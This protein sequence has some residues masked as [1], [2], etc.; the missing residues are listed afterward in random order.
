MKDFPKRF[1]YKV[2]FANVEYSYRTNSTKQNVLKLI[3][4]SLWVVA[5]VL[6]LTATIRVYQ[7]MGADSILWVYLLG[8]ASFVTS[9]ITIAKLF[10]MMLVALR[11]FQKKPMFT[12]EQDAFEKEQPVQNTNV[13][14]DALAGLASATMLSALGVGIVLTIIILL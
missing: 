3:F 10:V 9:V 7:V 11:S 8:V 1:N 12:L 14:F 6:L 4:L 2:W 5:S 13:V